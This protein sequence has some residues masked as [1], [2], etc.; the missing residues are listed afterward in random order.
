MNGIDSTPP[1]AGRP[2][3]ADGRSRDT[4]SAPHF[5]ARLRA[6]QADTSPPPSVSQAAREPGVSAPPT[7]TTRT[8][9]P[10]P[11]KEDAHGRAAAPPL[12][13]RPP[14]HGQQRSRRDERE[15]MDSPNLLALLA[16][17]QPPIVPTGAEVASANAPQ[18]LTPHDVAATVAA[19]WVESPTGAVQVEASGSRWTFALAD[20]LTPLATLRVSG[21]PESG[22]A[23]R[24]TSGQGLPARQLAGRVERLRQ[25]LL[26]R[27]QPV[28]QLDID[29]EGD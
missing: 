3:A 25:R 14:A 21:D 22:W 23:L 12:A 17:T 26:A 2:A 11:S 15:T 18:A 24:L 7:G 20:P 28:T 13:H 5:E 29:E 6:A 1:S 16:A 27:G 8:S 4:D 9:R 19:A 10:P